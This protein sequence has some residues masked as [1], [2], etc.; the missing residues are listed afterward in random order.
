[1]KLA[2]LVIPV[3]LGLG[4]TACNDDTAFIGTYQN[5]EKQL[6][7]IDK[8]NTDKHFTVETKIKVKTYFGTETMDSR[9]YVVYKK[10]DQLLEL[11]NDSVIGELGKDSFTLS[12]NG[13]TYKKKL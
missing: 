9:K 2:K 5:A 13:I 3:L 8:T 1:M 4:L 6:L 12:I 11:G 10:G 7:Y